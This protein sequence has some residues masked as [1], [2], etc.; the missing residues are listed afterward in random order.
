MEAIKLSVEEFK[1]VLEAMKKERLHIKQPPKKE[2][3]KVETTVDVNRE[4]RQWRG[5]F[6]DL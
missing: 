4:L 3:I 6:T 1:Q 2:K 5:Y